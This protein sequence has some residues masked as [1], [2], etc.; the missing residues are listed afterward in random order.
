MKC[1]A[2]G[3]Q[4]H[5]FFFDLRRR[6]EDLDILHGFYE[7]SLP[8]VVQF[9]QHVVEQKHRIASRFLTDQADLRELHGKRRRPL[10]TLGT[11]RAD[12]DAVDLYLQVV[13]MRSETG[14][15]LIDIA[16]KILFKKNTELLFVRD[17]RFVFY[18]QVFLTLGDIG[19]NFAAQFA[20][21]F[22]EFLSFR[23]DP[24]AVIR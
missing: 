1:K 17:L 2:F 22:R 8:A 5:D 16:F 20:Q 12:I 15:S 23:R 6:D 21:S 13:F 9:R 14:K 24:R 11:E 19:M 4:L 10:L 18:I 7:I 3:Q